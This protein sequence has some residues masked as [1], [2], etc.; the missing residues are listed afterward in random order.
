MEITGP[1]KSLFFLMF[2][3]ALGYDVGPKFFRSLR[4]DAVPQLLLT[5]VVRI[6]G[7]AGCRLLAS[8]LGY[9]PG[10]AAGPDGAD[11]DGA[12]EAQPGL[13]VVLD[14]LPGA[15][16]AGDADPAT[17]SPSTC[18]PARRHPGSVMPGGARLLRTARHHRTGPASPHAGPPSP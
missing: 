6:G 12:A 16:D 14:D 4:K 15:T 5:L 17:S 3:F 9:G 8:L 7:L 10:L 18:A 11:G 13:R 1:I 2:L